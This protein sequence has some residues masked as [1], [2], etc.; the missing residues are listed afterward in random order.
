MK[1]TSVYMVKVF[2]KQRG[3]FVRNKSI[4]DGLLGFLKYV[5]YFSR[6]DKS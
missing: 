1:I 3:R 2:W 6:L 5:G 4:H